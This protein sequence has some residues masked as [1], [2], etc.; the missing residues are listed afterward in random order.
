MKKFI[1]TLLSISMLLMMLAGLSVSVS[2]AESAV[3]DG[4]TATAF[5]GGHGTAEDPYQIANGAQL[6]LMRD[7]VNNGSASDAYFKLIDDITLNADINNPTNVS[8]PIGV[9]RAFTG[10]FDGNGKTISGL[11]INYDGADGAGMFAVVKGGTIKNFALVNSYIESTATTNA[12]PETGGLIAFLNG[13]GTTIDSVYIHAT[14]KGFKG[15]VGGFVGIAGGSSNETVIRNCAFEGSVYSP[16]VYI[17]GIVGC[18]NN[19]DMLIVNCLNLGSITGSDYNSGIIGS[20]MDKC[21][22]RNCINLNENVL[23]GIAT[24][25]K[26]TNPI[27]IEDCWYMG[28]IAGMTSFIAATN[29]NK[30]ENKD[31]FIGTEATICPEGFSKRDGD[32]IIPTTLLEFAPRYLRNVTVTW[33]NGDDVLATEEYALGATPSYKGETPTKA[34]DDK[35]TYSFSGWYPEVAPLTADAIFEAQFFR[36]EKPTVDTGTDTTDTTDTANTDTG[37]VSTDTKTETAENSETTP[38]DDDGCGSVIGGGAVILVAVMG[39]AA[40]F[41]AKRKED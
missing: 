11:Y 3:W 8:T 26:D 13:T 18:G 32:V 19:C 23:Y 25:T 7:W 4:T 30:I 29:V 24:S 17:G 34:E 38:A 31:A 12:C 15:N 37:V 39:S 10:T 6:A 21:T 27:K 1:G 41:V 33:K 36:T 35:Y 2:A 28:E 40:M 9:G 22:V 16:S 14:V 20:N 5:A